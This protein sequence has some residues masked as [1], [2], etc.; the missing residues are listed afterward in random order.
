MKKNNIEI[1]APSGSFDALVAAVRSGANAV[2][3]GSKALNA[4]RNATNFDNEELKEAVAYCHERGVKV[5]QTL[6]TLMYDDEAPEVEEAVKTAVKCGVDALI[7]QDLGVFEIAKKIAPEMPLHASTQMAIHN[8]EG[9]K[10]AE[11]LGF[12]RIV[13]ARELS[14]EEIRHIAQN[15]HTEIEVF[16]HG[17]LCMSVSGQCYMS[18][19]IGER[20]GNRG[21]CAQP[22]RLPFQVENGNEYGLSLKDLSLVEDVKELADI[23]VVSVKIE[24]R[25]KRPEYV[26]A[27]VSQVK[28]AVNNEKTDMGLLRSVFSRSGFTDG[29]YN[30]KVDY[31]MFGTRQ[32]DD[33]LA[34]SSV[35]KDIEKD[36]AKEAALIPIQMELS[37]KEGEP[38]SLF[39]ADLE[40]HSSEKF[41][42]IPQ[43][44]IN[45]PTTREKAEQ[46]LAK[47]G[48]TPYYLDKFDFNAD[49]G[50][51]V[52]VSELNSLRR[53][54]L[55]D[56]KTQRSEVKPMKLCKLPPLPKIPA[57]MSIMPNLRARVSKYTQLTHRML[58][59][60]EMIIM[61][62]SQLNAFVRKGG[63][64]TDKICGEIEA[65][66]FAP[67]YEIKLMKSLK[68]QGL[69]HIYCG[70]LWG[71]K[72]AQDIGIKN[73]HGGFNLNIFNSRAMKKYA[74][75]GICDTETS[76][77]LNL[78]KIKD[79][80]RPIS[81]GIVAYGYLPLMTVRNCPVEASIGCDNCLGYTKLKDRKGTEFF[82]NCDGGQSR[83][84]NSVP[85]YLAERMKEL[86][87]LNFITLYFTKEKPEECDEIIYSYKNKL[88]YVGNMT[89]G[90]YY[91]NV[92]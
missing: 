24:G 43:V 2:Y 84:F 81:T 8:L 72:A 65:V 74:D 11:E 78:N 5:H 10:K 22:C 14:K 35:L 31:S 17:A 1:L 18:S 56:I 75:M 88:P 51:I 4:R 50:L 61:P 15:I 48:G 37:I 70:N 57:D 59:E 83:I 28:K 62:L 23:G 52:P 69:N 63:A 67:E 40:G 77:E 64:I 80:I 92:L 38:V 25:M 26:S 34:M 73:I 66:N 12:S 68:E 49:E 54:A 41:G 20:S 13:L 33:V 86:S 47:T 85:L 44:A 27:A 55:E 87:G 46:S 21:L 79:I 90:L 29:Y 82:V 19:M 91:R 6:N 7:I 42:A 58:Q 30:S 76:F 16:I 36:Y 71:I 89:R 9:A 3:L 60:C 45:K 39:C 32:K 53:E